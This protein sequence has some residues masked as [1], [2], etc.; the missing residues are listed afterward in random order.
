MAGPA[1]FGLA[2]D[3]ICGRSDHAALRDETGYPPNAQRSLLRDCELF[4]H[5]LQEFCTSHA[6]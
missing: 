3:L 1:V 5:G 6:P 2:G 4:S